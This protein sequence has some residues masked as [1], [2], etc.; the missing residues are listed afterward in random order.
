MAFGNEALPGTGSTR[1]PRTSPDGPGDDLLRRSW[2]FLVLL[3][4]VFLVFFGRGCSIGFRMYVVDVFPWWLHL[5]IF[6]IAAEGTD[7]GG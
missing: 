7:A 2:R 3:T 1:R 4:H 5:N 6:V